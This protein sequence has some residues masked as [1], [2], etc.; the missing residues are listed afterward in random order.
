M[1][2]QMDGKV[3]LVTGAG[4]GIGRAC[5]LALAKAR[6]SLV[7][8]DIEAQAGDETRDM[9][10]KQG[11]AAL[12]VQTDVA[13]SDAVHALMETAVQRFGGLDCAVN[14]AGIEGRL[15]PTAE[16]SEKNWDR[17]IAVN[18]KGVW[19]CMREEIPRM[20]ERGGGTIVNMA[21]VAGLVGFEGLPAYC[22]SKGG[23]VQLTRTAALE[24]AT[25]GIRVNAI[26]PGVIRTAMVERILG[27]D[28]EQEKA[29][30]AMEPVGRM[31]RPEE[32]ASAALWLCSEASSFV[33]GEA[34][35]VDGGFIAR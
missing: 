3:A 10:E 25:R 9:I 2:T 32:I 7:V 29:F 33:T 8:S 19:L 35:A 1:S 16:C 34:M 31:G 6:A 5:A 4:A 30:T 15:A 27:G 14:N 23:V 22:A 18:L 21:S 20:L 12:F 17:T 26:C 24:Y 28:P 11:G 13:D